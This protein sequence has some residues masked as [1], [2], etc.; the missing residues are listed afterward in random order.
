[1]GVIRKAIKGVV[2]FS[3]V[4]LLLALI[5]S[6]APAE[7]SEASSLESKDASKGVS[8]SLTDPGAIQND[9]V[10]ST[11]LPA[12]ANPIKTESNESVSSSMSAASLSSIVGDNEK[13]VGNIA[14]PVP[15]SYE[16][17][18][19][20]LYSIPIQIPLGRN[21][22]QP[23][24]NLAYNS[25]QKNSWVGVGWDLEMGAIQRST[26]RGVDY[27]A[28]DYVVVKEGYSS[29]LVERS[30]WGQNFYGARIE[31]VFTKYYFNPVTGGWEAYARDGTKY[32]YGSR[33]VS[34]QDNMHG[35]F[36][37]CLD[38]VVDTHGNFM[39]VTYIKDQGQIYLDEIF[40]T[41]H[42]SLAPSNYIKFHLIDR[43][44]RDAAPMYGTN[45]AVITAKLLN[46]IDVQANGERVRTY[47]F[48]YTLNLKSYRSVLTNI[49]QYGTD[50]E[51]EPDGSVTGG[52]ALPSTDV[53]WFEGG[54]GTFI[55]ETTTG[56]VGKNSLFVDVNG[57]GLDDLI[58]HSSSVVYTYL[59]IGGGEYD[60]SYTITGGPG[61][62][63]LF[64]DVN[65]DGK[66]DLVKYDGSGWVYTYLSNGNGTYAG[67]KVQGGAAGNG[68]GYVNLADVSGDGNADLIKHDSSGWV[69]TFLSNGDG[70]YKSGK[71]FGGG[72]GN[73]A[74]RV[75]FADVNGDGR[76]DLIKLG[77]NGLVYSYLS[78]GNGTYCC[79]K[80][81][82]GGGLSLPGF[83][84]FGDINGD[85]RFDM[86]KHRYDGVV[87]TFI[88]RGDGGFVSGP[89][90]YGP[91]G[92]G[93]N[94]VWFS[95]V[96]GDGR[97]DLI[98]RGANG[99]AYTSIS[100]GSGTYTDHTTIDGPESNSASYVHTADVDGDGRSDIIKLD[101]NGNVYTFLSNGDGPP[102]HLRSVVSPYGA[103]SSIDYTP[104]SKYPN[105]LMPFIIYALSSL[106]IDDGFGNI[107]TSTY[108]YSGGLF[109]FP[110]RDFRGFE[111]V[112]QTRA[113]GTPYETVTETQFHQDDFL[114]GRRKDVEVKEPS[115]GEPLSKISLSWEK[116]YL[117]EPEN[118]AA[119]VKLI[120]ERIEYYDSVT[121][122]TQ[123]DYTY[124]DSN[125]NLLTKMTSGTVGEN[126]TAIYEY[127]NFG[128]WLWRRTGKQLTAAPAD[129]LEKP[130]L[131]MKTPP[132]TC[133][134]G[135]LW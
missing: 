17:T 78:N 67:Y 71:V 82:G 3:L 32:F 20:V 113:V 28:D 13:D 41:G 15:D 86:V 101:G 51:L 10:S 126:V 110:A 98:K 124:D 80:V 60:Q 70:T 37:W 2:C 33:A 22:I 85:G 52:T 45:S 112:V 83:V 117:D 30:E 62:Y 73:G 58:K 114:K 12:F 92:N 81:T 103:T 64:A 105:T 7:E 106:E 36:K 123:Q 74:N 130:F 77:N 102:D 100:D 42:S 128:E 8:D 44:S 55:H 96:N 88:S 11:D 99:V 93:Q 4:F 135:S 94:N 116:V 109:D 97:A 14:A 95:D 118:T 23:L 53:T 79:G 111:S 59:S 9:E 46:S 90:N 75:M 5:E 40:Y 131:G 120:Q 29:E 19:A 1:M 89:A 39:E 66:A 108:S 57:D 129:R 72:G 31:E 16:F 84:H 50:A 34:R 56:S 134:P 35:I 115:A 47:Q 132:E 63:V 65:G 107:S 18:G 125:G 27:Y 91:G 127:E 54:G 24:L 26:K 119:F 43:D 68:A 25:Y 121:V 104:S 6:P 49:Q 61:Y 87:F 76:A 69:Y 38:K 21:G 48:D 133:Y 122:Y